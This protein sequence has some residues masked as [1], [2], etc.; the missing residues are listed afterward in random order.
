MTLLTDVAGASAIDN[1][2]VETKQR[3]GD[4]S[5][6]SA[7]QKKD[8][9]EKQDV[10]TPEESDSESEDE[11]QALAAVT[12]AEI[13]KKQSVAFSALLRIPLPKSIVRTTKKLNIGCQRERR[14]LPMLMSRRQSKW[15]RIV[16]CRC[17]S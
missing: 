17:L 3:L 1:S 15:R 4:Y 2:A 12:A 9:R 5:T 14:L 6:L 11:A 13:R 7:D 16:N 10:E 8:E